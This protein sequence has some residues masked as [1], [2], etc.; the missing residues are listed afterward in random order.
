MVYRKKKLATRWLPIVITAFLFALFDKSNA[1]AQRRFPG[2]FAPGDAVRIITWQSPTGKGDVA[3]LGITND[4]LIDRRGQIFL[5]LIGYVRVVGLTREALAD[6]LVARYSK[7]ASGLQFICKPL[8]RIAVLGAVNKP[9]TYVVEPTESL[10][11]VITQAGGPETGADFKKMYYMRNGQVVAEN[12]LTQFE[13]AYSI[14]EIGIV[15]GDQLYVPRLSSFKFRT[16][17]DYTSFVSTVVLLYF[18]IRDRS[19]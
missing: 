9:G 16:L 4:Y 11:S 10:W 13:R 3:K 7:Y 8:I 2:D 17:L 6:T 12:L 14:E 19:R 5:P 15:S 18:T 1:F